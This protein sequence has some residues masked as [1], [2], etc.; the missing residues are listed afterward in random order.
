MLGLLPLF[1]VLV[2]IVATTDRNRFTRHIAL[3]LHLTLF[4]ASDYELATL[5]PVSLTL[6]EVA[7]AWQNVSSSEFASNETMLIASFLV[8]AMDD[9][10]VIIAVFDSHLFGTELA[11]IEADLELISVVLDARQANLLLDKLWHL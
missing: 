3:V 9:D 11:A 10:R 6:A 4:R 7:F 1:L 5:A 8:S 2:P